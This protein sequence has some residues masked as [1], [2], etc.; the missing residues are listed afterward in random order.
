MRDA[1]MI[2]AASKLDKVSTKK[3]LLEGDIHEV[4]DT[5]VVLGLPV[6]AVSRKNG[7]GKQHLSEVAGGGKIQMKVEECEDHVLKGQ[8]IVK[9]DL[10]LEEGVEL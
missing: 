4:L 6:V 1:T 9:R 10:I 7:V 2:E 8:E 3:Y 5:L